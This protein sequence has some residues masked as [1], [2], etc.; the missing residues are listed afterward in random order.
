MPTELKVPWKVILY[1]KREIREKKCLTE[2][3]NAY[4]QGSFFVY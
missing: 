2:K 1:S 4:V 3:A